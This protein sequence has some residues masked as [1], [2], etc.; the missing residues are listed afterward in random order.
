MDRPASREWG[1]R[2]ERWRRRGAAAC[3]LLASALGGSPAW[4]QQKAIRF[5]R[6][7]GLSQSAVNCVYQDR[8]GFM[9]FGTEDGLNRF[10]GYSFEVFRREAGDPGSLSHSFVWAVTEDTEG[11]L[12]VATEGGLNRRAPGRLHFTRM[13]HDPNDPATIGADFVWTLLRDR[14]GAIWA[15]T[16]GGGLNRFEPASGRFTRHRHQPGRADSLPHDDVRAL[17]ESRSGGL[18]VGTMGGGLAK[19]DP[20]TGRFLRFR[21]DPKDPRSLPDDEVRSLHEDGEGRL[22]VGTMKGGLARLSADTGHFVR[23]GH[24][25]TRPASL[26]KGMIRSIG[27][28][29][30]GHLWIATDGGLSRWEPESDSFTSFRHDPS[31]PFSLSDDAITALFSDAGGV[32]WVGTKT[33]GLNRWNP[34]SGVFTSYATDPAAASTLSHRVVTSFAQGRDGALWIGTF[35]G[36]LNRLDR[37]TLRY[38]ALRADGRPGSLGDDRVMSLL[39]DRHGTLWAGTL[40]AG[41]HRLPAGASRFERH[42]HRPG[43]AASLSNDGVTCL[44]QTRDGTLWA[45]TYG[46]GLNQFDA[47]GRAFRHFRHD[48]ANPHSLAGD[49]ITALAEDADGTLWVAI[50]GGGLDAL[51]PRDGQVRHVRH[52]ERDTASLAADTVFSLFVDAAGTLWL[53]TEGAG[54]DR[55][56]AADRRAGREVFRHYTRRHGLPND[57]VYSVLGDEQGFVWASTNRGLFRLDPRD[58]AVRTYDTSHGLPGDEFNYGAALRSPSG[59]MFFGGT[60]GFVSFLPAQ[61]RKNQHVPPVVLTGVSTLNRPVAFAAPLSEVR[62]VEIGWRDYLFSFEF[63]ALDFTAPER[64]RY[65]YRLEGLDHDW[66]DAGA[67]RRA[68]YTNAAP[69]TYTFRVKAAND[70]GV[71][72]DEGLALRV[73]VV[74]PPWRTPWAYAGYLLIAGAAGYGWLRSQRRRRVREI[75]YSRRLEREVAARTGELAERNRELQEA[76]RRLEEASLT[77][78]LTGLHNRR[79]FLNE[80][81]ADLA[82]VARQ[83]QQEPSLASS[84]LFLMVDLDGFKELNDT[85]GHRAGD[86]A[87]RQVTGL[88]REAC[89]RSDVIIRWGGDE[90][91]VVGRQTERRGGDVLAERIRTL[92][93]RHRFE[94]EGSPVRLSCSVGFAL[95]P[96]A[97]ADPS[98][99]SW[100]QVLM[101]ADRALY[102]AKASGRNAWVGIEEG[103]RVSP[104]LMDDIS[105]DLAAAVTRGL[106][107][108]SCRLEAGATLI[109]RKDR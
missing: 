10:D 57:V 29:A 4:G 2:T 67:I 46:G 88:L 82:L 68:T 25:P 98:T 83:R 13:R 70:D 33:A 107:K 1:S 5:E 32:L 41:L 73:R 77:D 91:L 6:V 103:S 36:G 30:R 75:E 63:A 52:D 8:H 38:Q 19:L 61:L 92:V 54:L 64:N 71:W 9:W 37:Q 106:L 108:V 99:L 14:G 26:G 15:G 65:A 21:H 44:L 58:G 84:Y 79:F 34:S 105:R 42:R 51:D 95:Y 62:E 101:I 109:L 66:I 7:P 53:G 48:P 11:G 85:L 20:R 59:E 72:N 50:R 47:A 93:G 39:I 55:W 96:F 74:P 80:I 94:V 76:N 40:A 17:L 81:E 100:E 102:V 104:E 89:R 35:G 12:W 16:K 18:W 87:L 27:Q 24:D 49:V 23:Y 45:G 69:G 60:E 28:D 97:A 3:A 56:D 31:R 22:W 86:E 43:D 90:F 78:S